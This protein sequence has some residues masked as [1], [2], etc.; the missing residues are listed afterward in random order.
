MIAFAVEV[1][2]CIDTPLGSV[3]QYGIIPV[4]TMTRQAHVADV[5]GICN[6]ILNWETVITFVPDRRQVGSSH[7][8]PL[9]RYVKFP[10]AQTPGMPETFSPPPT[11]KETTN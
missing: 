8:G 3:G 10:V 5:N 2:F 11:S 6:E 7:Q 1:Y 4:P 9:T